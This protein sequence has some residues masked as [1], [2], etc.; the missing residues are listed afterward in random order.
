MKNKL[1]QLHTL[2]REEALKLIVDHIGAPAGVV[3]VARALWLRL[4]VAL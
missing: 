4:R 1:P 2:N 3:A